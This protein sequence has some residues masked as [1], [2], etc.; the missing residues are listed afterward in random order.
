MPIIT[1]QEILGT[2]SSSITAYYLETF[3]LGKEE[4]K[5]G[6]LLIGSYKDKKECNRTVKK[7]IPCVEIP[8]YN[9]EDA[10]KLWLGDVRPERRRVKREE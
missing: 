5:E 7:F 9:K 3:E 4:E 8:L 2:S 6:L 10:L 1:T